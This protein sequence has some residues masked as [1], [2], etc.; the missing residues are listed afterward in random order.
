METILCP[1]TS[2][3]TY[4]SSQVNFLDGRKP[5][6]VYT[7]MEQS[8]FVAI[9]IEETIDVDYLGSHLTN[10][11]GHSSVPIQL[12]NCITVN[13]PEG[14]YYMVKVEGLRLSPSCGF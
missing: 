14:I 5:Q 4:Q 11:G 10:P 9:F 2:G 13:V 3:N 1:E 6:P 12:H 8:A 7:S